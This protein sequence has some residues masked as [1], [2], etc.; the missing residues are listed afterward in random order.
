MPRLSSL[1]IATK[2]IKDNRERA[3]K[4]YIEA[5]KADPKSSITFRMLENEFGVPKSS[6][7]RA[8][9]AIT[10]NRSVG[11]R[12]RPEILNSYTKSKTLKWIEKRGEEY[13]PPCFN[14]LRTFLSDK[15]YLESRK[16]TIKNESV[17]RNFVYKFIKDN[18]LKFKM[19]V[20][21]KK[22][23]I[24]VPRSIV[25]NFFQKFDNL[26]LAHHYDRKLIFNMDESWVCYNESNKGLKVVGR[27]DSDLIIKEG[28]ESKHFTAVVCI[29]ANGRF[30]P[31]RYLS[32]YQTENISMLKEHD[33]ERIDCVYSP[34]GWMNQDQLFQWSKNVFL[35]Y[36]N[37]IRYNDKNQ[38][39]ILI[40]DGHSSRYSLEFIYLLKSENI[41]VITFP[42]SCTSCLQPLDLVIFGPYKKHL[43]SFFTE[44]NR[45]SLLNASEMAFS[46]S[47]TIK[48][49]R[50]AW[51]RSTLLNEDHIDAINRFRDI[52]EDINKKKRFSISNQILTNDDFIDEL[53]KKKQSI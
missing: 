44:N 48:K 52:P 25:L 40:L 39:G 31:V 19:G 53:K 17:S 51:D 24:L 47:L 18:N 28:V 21:T 45:Y 26:I 35:P 37:G 2:D 46:E 34:S 22:E 27:S 50:G 20:S 30:V 1:K 23:G 29:S 32:P 41:D 43:K 15:I 8:V 4:V 42:A 16:S 9:S 11:K 38:R 3:A 13:K 33:L 5:N 10:N 49:I 12:G 14:E 36:V 6:I 7:E